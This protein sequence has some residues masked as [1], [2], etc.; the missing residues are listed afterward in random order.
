MLGKNS[1]IGA[2]IAQ[3]NA[4]RNI[5]DVLHVL[6]E[7][8]GM[9]FAVIARVSATN[10]TACAVLDRLGMGIK[11]GHELDVGTTFCR[12]VRASRATIA[13]DSVSTDCRYRNHL[14][15]KMYGFESYISVPII[16]PDGDYF[17]SLCTLDRRAGGV[18]DIRIQFM[19]LCFSRLIAQ[20][21]QRA[22]HLAADSSPPL[23]RLQVD[24]LR[25]LVIAMLAA[26]DPARG[27]ADGHRALALDY[28]QRLVEPLDPRCSVI[29][30][31]VKV[32]QAP[33]C[34]GEATRFEM[35]SD[36]LFRLR[37]VVVACRIAHPGRQ[38]ISN[39]AFAGAIYC[40]PAWIERLAHCLLA[41]ALK[42]GNPA[43]AV[44]F[45]AKLKANGLL[46][47]VWNNGHTIRPDRVAGIFRPDWRAVADRS[48][49]G[50]AMH[51]CAEVV[52]VHHGTIE[53]SSS[54]GNGTQI[55]ARIPLTP[56]TA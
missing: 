16:L 48:T 27:T 4:I 54:P 30:D 8:T 14:T 24:N 39:I 22:R 37:A 52:R 31:A 23:S 53:A 45:I 49:S 12:E 25:G 38:I 35:S 50:D 10:W 44:S 13:I 42:H 21:L 56:R 18:S 1:A 2:D 29:A 7:I 32:T 11:T 15:P 36:L 28:M 17:G 41:Y 33:L 46:L 47:S 3:V 55:S 5:P 26:D 9:K 51:T 40:D 19:F 20:E 34:A 6:C 43:D